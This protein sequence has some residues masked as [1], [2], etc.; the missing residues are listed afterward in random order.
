MRSLNGTDSTLAHDRSSPP[1]LSCGPDSGRRAARHDRGESLL[2]RQ[3]NPPRSWNR[4]ASARP[5]RSGGAGATYRE[6]PARRLARGP[7]GA[8]R[9][10]DVPRRARRRHNGPRHAGRAHEVAG[11][12]HG[13]TESAQPARPAKPAR[14]AEG[15]RAPADEHLLAW[16]ALEDNLAPGAAGGRDQVDSPEGGRPDDLEWPPARSGDAAPDDDPMAAPVDLYLA[17]RPR[18][19]CGLRVNCDRAQARERGGISR[20]HKEDA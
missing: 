14:P 12:E 4:A 6:V 2:Y 5:A 8:G 10:R 7:R 19:S 15:E 20:S 1:A 13:A 17:S 3:L 18:K 16:P 9:W 11:H